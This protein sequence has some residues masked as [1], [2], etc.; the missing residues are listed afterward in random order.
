MTRSAPCARSGSTSARTARPDVQYRATLCV[1]SA[2]ALALGPRVTLARQTIPIRRVTVRATLAE[3]IRT[4]FPAVYELS[5]ST[6]LLD[7]G[8]ARRAILLDSALE[9]ARALA[10]TSGTAPLPWKPEKL[11]RFLGDTMLRADLGSRSLLVILPDGRPGRSMAMPSPAA[12]GPIVS[13]GLVATDGRGRL[14]F[15][16][17]RPFS[18]P[19]PCVPGA[20]N[21][22]PPATLP[23]VD[24]IPIER[25]DFDRRSIDTVA[26]V[27]LANNSFAPQVLKDA[28]CKAVSATVRVDPSMPVVDSWTVTSQGLIAIVRGHDYHIDWIDPNGR[29][30]STPKMP[31][32]WRRITD[33]E[34]QAKRDSARSVIDSVTTAGGYRLQVCPNSY[35]LYTNAPPPGRRLTTDDGGGRGRGGDPERPVDLCQVVSVTAR[36]AQLG[37]MPDYIAPIREYSAL[38]DRDGNVWILPTT[39]LSARGGLL[40]DVVNPLGQLTHRV[41]L[42]AGR[43]IAGF[44]ANGVVYLS[45]RDTTGY[46]TIERVTIDER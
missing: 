13:S 6:I 9:H 12:I 29:R 45:S 38:A 44:G 33:E 25:G 28:N 2:F 22:V 30:R 36:Y 15:Q 19:Q 23:A 18:V 41:Q 20:L 37:E 5:P 21:E 42:P 31:F 27:R 4:S 7:D 35:A 34:K 10:D 46:T 24:T 8:A 11:I 26:Y 14:V 16:G 3:P 39:T 17:Q 40:Y 43:A 1:A 32:D